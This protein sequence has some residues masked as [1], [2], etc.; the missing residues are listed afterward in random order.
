MA[1]VGE[2]SALTLDEVCKY[3]RLSRPTVRKL[4]VRG[5]IPARKAG[6]QWRVLKAELDRYL[7][8]EDPRRKTG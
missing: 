5:E 7:K 2:R 4:F 8:G 6:K 3:L 1:M